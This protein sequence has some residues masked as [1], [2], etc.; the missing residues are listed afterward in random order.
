[1]VGLVALLAGLSV[2]TSWMMA[3]HLRQDASAIGQLY[4][5]VFA[6]LNDP[7]PGAAEDALLRLGALVREKGLP[8][9]VTDGLGQ[10]TAADNLPFDAELNDPRVA[11][12]AKEL[13]QVRAPIRSSVGTVHFGP[14]PTER[15]LVILSVLQ[16]ITLLVMVGVGFLAFRTAVNARRDRVWVAMAREAAHQLGTPLTS[17]QGWI[18]QMRQ[19]HTPPDALA[20]F[21]FQDTERLARVAR[22]FERIGS[23]MVRKPVGLGALAA[24]VAEYF[25][26]RLP[27]HANP[28]TIVVDAPGTGP[29]VL[30]DE[31]LLEWALESLVKNAIDA[32]KG[33]SGSIILEAGMSGDE[34]VLR[35]S[36]DGPG[37]PSDLGLDIFEPGISSKTSGWGIGLALV[38]RV[39]E[40]NHEGVVVVNPVPVGAS[41][42]IRMPV[43]PT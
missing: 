31:V 43:Q 42:E 21:L 41:F 13:D 6:G 35:V 9:V 28:I 14:L 34:A 26:P 5:G 12:F 32:L 38:K 40:E 1:V 4:S 19:G 23:P 16:G 30:G 20:D 2:G 15:Q 33:R 18:E 36:D 37:I 7:R 24:R 11:A 17:L 29:T 8:L 22:R 10:V 3:R 27:R 39:V 25:R